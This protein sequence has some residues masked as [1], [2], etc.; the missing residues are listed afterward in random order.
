MWSVIAAL[1]GAIANF[2][3]N[4][5]KSEQETIV[6]TANE[7][8]KVSA[9]VSRQIDKDEHEAIKKNDAATAGRIDDLN[10]AGSLH[11]ENSIAADAVDSAND[12]V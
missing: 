2:F 5:H 3:L 12:P 9:D 10:H 7:A 8:G 1:F 4:R 6:Q 11:A